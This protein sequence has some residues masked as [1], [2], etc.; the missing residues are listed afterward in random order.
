LS[1]KTRLPGRGDVSVKR[2]ASKSGGYCPECKRE[3]SLHPAKVGQFLTCPHCDIQL[4]VIGVHP[5][6]FD[7]AYDWTSEEE[8]EKQESESGKEGARVMARAFCPDCD[9]EVILNPHARLGQKL[10]CPHCD[11]DLEVTGVDPLEL[12]WA[13]VLTERDWGDVEDE[14]D[15]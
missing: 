5:L 3:I 7:S 14:E 15:W 9:G 8:D 13:H 10:V 4:E 1:V 6:E 12:D 2:E 11:A